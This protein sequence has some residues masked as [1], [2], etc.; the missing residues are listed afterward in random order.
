MTTTV[1]R[2]LATAVIVGML[3][4]GTPM[5][6]PLTFTMPPAVVRVQVCSPGAEAW[7][8]FFPDRPLPN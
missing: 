5:R 3:A 7:R 8:A 4:F 1:Q 6:R 2:R